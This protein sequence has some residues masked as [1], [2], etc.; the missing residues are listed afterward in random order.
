MRILEVVV[1]TNISTSLT[2][3]K[4]A[5]ISKKKCNALANKHTNNKLTYAV[6]RHLPAFN[7]LKCVLLLLTVIE[8]DISK[9]DEI[10]VFV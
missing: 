4:I 10:G 6:T 9:F 5:P 2:S 1:S 7:M 3:F 8:R